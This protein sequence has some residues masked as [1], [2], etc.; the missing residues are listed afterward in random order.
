MRLVNASYGL[1]F[2]FSEG[3]AEVLVIENTSAFRHIASDLWNQ[4]VG[5][6]GSFVLSNNTVLY[7]KQASSIL[8]AFR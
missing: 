3:V 5:S 6:D 4:C 2:M 8:T 7:K 1:D